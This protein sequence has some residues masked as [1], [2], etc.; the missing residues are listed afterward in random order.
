MREGEQPPQPEEQKTPTISRRDVLKGGAALGLATFLGWRKADGTKAASAPGVASSNAEKVNQTADIIKVVSETH[1]VKV[2]LLPGSEGGSLPLIGTAVDT[3]GE[4][5]GI[6]IDAA[7]SSDDQ[8]SS[9]GSVRINGT[10]MNNFVISYSPDGWKVNSILLNTS[11]NNVLSKGDSLKGKFQLD[12][13]GKTLTFTKE[14]DQDKK[15]DLASPFYSAGNNVSMAADTA[16]NSTLTMKKLSLDL[17]GG[18]QEEFTQN[19]VPLKETAKKHAMKIGSVF[20]PTYDDAMYEG[21]FRNQFN[22]LLADYPTT[23]GLQL[24]PDKDTFD[25]N[26]AD[27]L[28]NFAKVNDMEVHI[29]HLTSRSVPNWLGKFDQ[30]SNTWTSNFSSDELKSMLAEHIQK[31]GEH[32]QA[33]TDIVTVVNEAIG[34]DGNWAQD[35][36]WNKNLPDAQPNGTLVYIPEA[37]KEAHKAFPK[38]ELIYNDYSNGVSNPKSDTMYQ[39][40]QEFLSEGVP[41]HGVGLQEH[42]MAGQGYMPGTGYKEQM[43]ENIKRFK[44]LGLKVHV[45]EYTL[46]LTNIAEA[47]REQVAAAAMQEIM[48]ACVEG[49]VDSFNLYGFMA[50]HTMLD[51]PNTKDHGVSV[52][53]YDESGKP[54]AVEQSMRDAL[55]A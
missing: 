49:G 10:G 31:V 13:G 21:T 15:F 26:L 9:Q 46:D 11:D 34:N 1:P 25:F 51:D 27:Q 48:E 52:F 2:D 8:S 42:L 33:D 23:W 53:P 40:C 47:D 16:K 17:P 5:L 3:R 20:D 6:D 24:R 29:Q 36:F 43:V 28:I 4:A 32:L 18:Q 39:M 37:F 45:T 41:I 55:A 35:N 22:L 7:I 30:S 12:K 54:T 14:G 50:N 19:G 44:D 38:A